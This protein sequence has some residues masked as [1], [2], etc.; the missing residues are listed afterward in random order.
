MVNGDETQ[1]EGDFYERVHRAQSPLNRARAAGEI[2]N[3][4][5]A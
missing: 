1:C 5:I 3:E 4:F 2:Q